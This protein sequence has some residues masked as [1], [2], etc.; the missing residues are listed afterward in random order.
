MS[1]FA[2]VSFNDSSYLE[3]IA[4]DPK[5][6]GPIGTLIKTKGIKQLTPFAFAVRTNRAEELKKEVEEFGY[7]PD[8]ITMFG[9]NKE[10]EPMKWEVSLLETIIPCCMNKL[11]PVFA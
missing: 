4:P 7:K 5:K 3:I 11:I 6:P 10:G 8:H 9:G 1:A 2:R